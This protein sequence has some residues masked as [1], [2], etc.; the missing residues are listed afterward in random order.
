[1]THRPQKLPYRS[2]YVHV[3][4]CVGGKCDYCAFAS[5]GG[6]SSEE[7]SA[8]LAALV[9]EFRRHSGRCAPLRSV[10]IGGGTPSSLPARALSH[11]LKSIRD[12]F[13]FQD[14]CEWSC[15]ANPD[16]LTSEKLSVMIEGGVN[17]IS[18]GV[19]TFSPRFRQSIGRRG[20]LERL[21]GIISEARALG[22]RRL[23]LDMIYALPGQSVDDWRGDLESAL[24]FA[25]DHL[26]CYSLILEEGTPLARRL[27]DF[28]EDEELFLECWR[29]NDELLERH[30]LRRY[31]ISN[32][33]REG[34]RCR[35]NFEVWHGQTYLGCGPAA[36]SFD[37][38]IR[39]ANPST[40]EEWLSGTPPEADVL[41]PYARAR[42]V[43][44]FGMRTVDGWGWQELADA[45]GLSRQDV[46][47]I[48]GLEELASG[49][50]VSQDGY[51]L[52]PTPRG[53]LFN[54]Q[55]VSA[56]LA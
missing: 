18:L 16:S 15:E 52:R 4:F 7:C 2:L 11:L 22:L 45:T 54:D 29:L 37:G 1:M 33:A 40:L 10:F 42:E 31:E 32:F 41:P 44:A 12:S 48:P 34:A 5:R 28:R 30:G 53:L 8:Y 43:L 21:P 39:Q 20:S 19:Q 24:G 56:L 50:L 23:N 27:A 14:D 3:P 13:E 47:A 25:P 26:S 51:G 49:G 36:V 55:V 46:E 9:E 38:E 35:H 6:C 17:R